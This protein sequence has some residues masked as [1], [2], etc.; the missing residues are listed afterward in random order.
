MKFCQ[1][2]RHRQLERRCA[3]LSGARQSEQRLFDNQKEHFEILAEYGTRRA[4][5]GLPV[6]DGKQF[7]NKYN[8]AELN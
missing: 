3:F 2:R 1:V 6:K 4:R 5:R 7:S 8:T